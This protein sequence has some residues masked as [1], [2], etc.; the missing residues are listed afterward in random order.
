[1]HGK[2]NTDLNG[3]LT[4]GCQVPVA[5]LPHADTIALPPVSATR[6]RGKCMSRRA[7][8]N[9]SVRI[10]LNRRKGIAE[11][12]FQYW[13]DVP[14]REKR[15]RETEVIGPVKTMTKSEAERKKLEFILN[16]KVNSNEYKIPSSLTFA[17]AAK[18]YREIFAPRMLRQ[19]TFSVADG[20]L[21]VHLE[22]DWNE[23]PVEHIDID[24][25]NEWIWKKRQ[26]DLS[27]V[28]IKNI[29]RTMQRVLSC[30]SNDKKPPFSQEGLAIPERDKLEK[31]IADEVYK[32]DVDDVLKERYAALFILASASGLRCAELFALRI[33]DLDFKAGTIRLDESADQ[34]TYIIGPCKNVAAYRTILLAD[35]EGREALFTLKRFLKGPQ[36]Q[37]S[38][39]FRSKR[40]TALRETCVLHTFLHPVLR[41][42]GFPQA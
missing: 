30:C 7:G 40:G 22:A 23:I 32:L 24:A 13:I 4:V 18:H 19:S 28:T 33:N 42:L 34:R 1:M 16:L 41:T 20:H 12:F 27:R 29:L 8:Q 10:R 37:T 5:T 6:K 38:F 11:Y 35:A 31:K 2:F 36:T 14:G 25:V 39:L 17:H 21:K 15:K 3:I 26:A 9:P